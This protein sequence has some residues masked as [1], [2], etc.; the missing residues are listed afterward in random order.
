MLVGYGVGYWMMTDD[1]GIPGDW[2]RT[3][4]SSIAR[5]T[6]MSGKVV[7]LCK[8]QTRGGW[9]ATGKKV[10]LNLWKLVLETERNAVG[11]LLGK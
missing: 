5:D 6:E 9:E 8:W 2:E 4:D 7:T 1:L 10:N 11:T 3:G